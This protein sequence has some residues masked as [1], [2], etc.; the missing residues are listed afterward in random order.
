MSNYAGGLQL[1]AQVQKTA[2]A[3]TGT[4]WIQ[5]IRVRRKWTSYVS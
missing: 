3:A 5:R 4:L 1:Y 2:Q